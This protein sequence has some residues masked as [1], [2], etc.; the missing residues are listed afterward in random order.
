MASTSKHYGDVNK[1]I[2]RVID[3]CT[4]PLQERSVRRLIRLF[5][6]DLER[7]GEIDNTTISYM[8]SALRYRLEEKQ[9]SRIETELQN[10]N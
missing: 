6:E 8:Q 7:S 4:T 10:G 1:W 9:Y 2:E 5:G 3:S